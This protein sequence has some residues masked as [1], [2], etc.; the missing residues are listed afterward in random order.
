MRK[1]LLHS[2]LGCTLALWAQLPPGYEERWEASRRGWEAAKRHLE[3]W[4]TIRLL[5]ELRLDEDASAR[6]LTRYSEYNR[7]IDSVL[8][9][10]DELS[11]RL[12]QLLEERPSPNQLQHSIQEMLAQQNA[13][14]QL[15]RQRT[16]AVRPLLTEEQFARYLLFEYRFP[17][18]VE[19]LLLHH[20][21]ARKP[22]HR[23]PR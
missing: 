4:K 12:N 19:L 10:L 8:Q 7:Q 22:Q 16:E 14:L 6:F 11:R 21:R 9:R 23:P 15:V 2:L 1:L 20:L 17:K 18:E 5:E 13:L 3:R